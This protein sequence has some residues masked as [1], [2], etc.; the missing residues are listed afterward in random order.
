MK[1]SN[2]GGYLRKLRKSKKMTIQQLA[3]ASGLSYSGISRMELNERGTP[4]PSTI[5]L[6]AQ[7]LGEPYELLMEKAGYMNVEEQSEYD[8]HLDPTVSPELRSLLDQISTLSEED[9]E[10]IINRALSFVEGLKAL[11]YK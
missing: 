8:Y 2:F 11:K 9:R 6:L 7:G 3:D 4:K 5:R 1:E 10:L